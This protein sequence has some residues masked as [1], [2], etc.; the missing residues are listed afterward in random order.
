MAEACCERSLPGG[1][2]RRHKPIRIGTAICGRKP[3]HRRMADLEITITSDAPTHDRGFA[4][5]NRDTGVANCQALGRAH[6]AKR[7]REQVTG[8]FLPQQRTPPLPG[9]SR[10][11]QIRRLEDLPWQ[12]LAPVRK[13]RRID[14]II[15]QY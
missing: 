12:S 13:N 11:L 8:E 4:R 3:L 10:T 2:H 9:H 7:M 14:C 6:H 15:L 5:D 1:K